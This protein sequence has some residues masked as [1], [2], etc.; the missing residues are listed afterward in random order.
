VV[1]GTFGIL[2]GRFFLNFTCF[3]NAS[4]GMCHRV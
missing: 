2:S 1:G 3:S 4:Q